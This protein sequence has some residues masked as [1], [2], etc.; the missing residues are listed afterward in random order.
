MPG[1]QENQEPLP[2][3]LTSLSSFFSWV[4][5]ITRRVPKKEC[6]NVM[7]ALLGVVIAPTKKGEP[8]LPPPQTSHERSRKQRG[9]KEEE[10][11]EVSSVA[12]LF[13]PALPDLRRKTHPLFPRPSFW[14]LC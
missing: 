8:R 14:V 13:F 7:G 12:W 6:R 10:E 11:E 4:L 2:P 9:R 5:G 1:K 3:P